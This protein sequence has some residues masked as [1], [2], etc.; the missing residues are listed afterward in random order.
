MKWYSLNMETTSVETRRSVS[1][2]AW[3]G[4]W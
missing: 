4:V 2:T 1:Q 3:L